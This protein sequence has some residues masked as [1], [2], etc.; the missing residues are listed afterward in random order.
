M[1]LGDYLTE[2]IVKPLNLT[3]TSWPTTDDLPRPYSN[4]Y[5]GIS[6]DLEVDEEGDSPGSASEVLR[7]YT[8]ASPSTTAGSGAMISTVGDIRRYSRYLGASGSQC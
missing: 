7:D 5:M 4:G 1:P 2:R 8:L 3:E 6:P